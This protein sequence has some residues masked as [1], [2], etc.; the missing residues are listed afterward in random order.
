MVEVAIDVGVVELDRRQENRG[1]TVVQELRLLVEV[2]RIVLV[3]LDHEPAPRPDGEAPAE[4][5]RHA[6]DEEARV[7]TRS[8]EDP[9][10]HGRG[11]RLP[12]GAGDDQRTPAGEEHLLQRRGHRRHAEATNSCGLRLRIRPR[13]RV[14]AHDELHAVE[15]GGVVPRRDRDAELGEQRARGWIDVLVRAGHGVT[16]LAEETRERAH[17][18]SAGRDQMYSHRSSTS[19]T[20]SWT[21][22]RTSRMRS[23]SRL[24]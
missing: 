19:I 15:A 18:D 14:P 5:A 16:A 11:G 12:V 20:A 6:A 8:R 24:G 1:G 3:T 17:P 23:L 21:R 2:R 7:A 4:I 10:E 22:G 13:D 9:G